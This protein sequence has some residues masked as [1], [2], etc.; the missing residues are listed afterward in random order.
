[1]ATRTPTPRALEHNSPL[2]PQLALPQQITPQVFSLDDLPPGLNNLFPTGG[3]RRFLSA[4]GS[5]YYA[6][7]ARTLRYV[8]KTPRFPV[9][10]VQLGLQVDFHG[11][12]HHRDVDGGLKATI[13]GLCKTIGT[14]DA[15]VEWILARRVA[16]R[17]GGPRAFTAVSVYVL[18]AATRAD[19]GW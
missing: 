1:M 14:D 5:R 2:L 16:R 12:G 8:Y 11:M 10:Q 4:E 13:D 3:H 7:V 6:E 17:T 19:V 9:P 15:Y 18:D